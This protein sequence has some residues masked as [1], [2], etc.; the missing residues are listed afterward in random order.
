MARPSAQKREKRG[1][2]ES[3]RTARYGVKEQGHCRIVAVTWRLKYSGYAY[4]AGRTVKEIS[5]RQCDWARE[6][7]ANC[8]GLKTG[9]L[10]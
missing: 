8:D 5:A 7:E 1:R 2:Y 9:P 4:L 6:V 3:R 10:F